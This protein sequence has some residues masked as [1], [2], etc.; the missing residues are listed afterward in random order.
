MVE[1]FDRL[2]ILL[3]RQF[4]TLARDQRRLY[5]AAKVA[6]Y[7]EE[8]R[9]ERAAAAERERQDE[10]DMASFEEEQEQEQ[11]M[12]QQSRGGTG[13]NSGGG[14][15]GGSVLA[16]AAATMTTTATTSNAGDDVGG[17]VSLTGRQPSQ[18]EGDGDAGVALG[19]DALSTSKTMLLLG[20][21]ARLTREHG[22]VMKSGWRKVAECI[23]VLYELEA[24]PKDLSKMGWSLGSQRE[25]KVGGRRGREDEDEDESADESADENAGG[26][27]NSGGG[28]GNSGN[29]GSSGGL[30]SALASFL[31]GSENQEEERQEHE[32]IIYRIQSCVDILNLG[33]LFD[34][35]RRLPKETLAEMTRSLILLRDPRSH[36]HHGSNHDALRDSNMTMQDLHHFER[37]S[38][39]CVDLLCRIM[40]SN[41]HRGVLVWSMLNPYFQR[42]LGADEVEPATT[43]TSNSVADVAA[44]AAVV[45]AAAA[46][47]A[48]AADSAAATTTAATAASSVVQASPIG[49]APPPIDSFD[50]RD[51]REMM[52]KSEEEASKN[53][54]RDKMPLLGGRMAMCVMVCLH[55]ML[56]LQG[57]M[58][59]DLLDALRTVIRRIPLQILAKT[60]TTGSRLTLA[61]VVGRSTVE[62]LI[63]NGGFLSAMGEVDGSQSWLVFI[64]HLEWICYLEDARPFVWQCIVYLVQGTL[65]ENGEE[66]KEGEGERERGGEGGEERDV[67]G[68][69]TAQSSTPTPT[70]TSTSTST[71][72]T[73]IDVH[74]FDHVLGLLSLFLQPVM[75]DAFH[76]SRPTGVTYDGHFHRQSRRKKSRSLHPTTLPNTEMQSVAA[77]RL[78]QQMF[79]SLMVVASDKGSSDSRMDRT[80]HWLRLL[81]VYK[82]AYY[83]IHERPAVSK[84]AQRLLEDILL[85]H[86]VVSGGVKI[87]VPTSVWTRCFN[88]I[89]FPLVGIGSMHHGYGSAPHMR[90]V[91]LLSRTVLHNFEQISILTGFYEL[92][93]TLIGILTT[94]VRSPRG[95]EQQSEEQQ[96]YRQSGRVEESAS[97]QLVGKIR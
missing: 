39:L 49:V 62:I 59:M 44:V 70:S 71:T 90:M 3:C 65:N 47:A 64:E 7:Q 19:D 92:W 53:F 84:E 48:A 35:S 78:T 43:S 72:G 5:N 29:S 56:Y 8:E 69:A 2:L 36:F 46:A 13:I 67:R 80:H 54:V 9:E 4:V 73:L 88:E 26:G 94:L 14:G 30:F 16:A 61:T 82:S 81:H 17:D 40:L 68:A 45:V 58:A 23:L 20:C 33:Q 37:E 34:L 93:L 57:G 63:K 18:S 79:T 6:E 25:H 32:R 42:L 85:G 21:I 41:A 55:R 86:C 76:T 38:C 11:A 97:S 95:G 50:D 22:H 87:V 77:L 1:Q 12:Q 24:L 91:T 75:T 51:R 15:G 66:T 28:G 31:V 10:R 74:N 96:H 83:L 89:M 27:G 52:D 60:R